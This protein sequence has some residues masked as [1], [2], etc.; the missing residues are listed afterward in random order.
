MLNNPVY[1]NGAIYLSG[2]MQ[3][4]KDLGAEWRIECSKILKSM[5]YN[6]VDIS[7]MDKEYTDK[8]G[9]LYFILD[10]KNHLQYKSNF[11]KHF[12][13]AD[14]EL[15]KNDCDALIVLYDESVR[16]GAGT[17][18]E[19]HEAYQLGLPVFLVSAYEDWH[20]EVPGWM[21]GETTK[22]FTSFQQLYEYLGY[23]S[24]KHPGILKKDIYG[25]HG[26]NNHYLCSLCG[27]VFEKSK[28]HFVSKVTPTYCSS[29]VDLITKTNEGHID[30]YEFI[31]EVLQNDINND[32]KIARELREA[33]NHKRST[34]NAIL[35]QR[36]EW[37]DK[38]QN[39]Y[40]EHTY[41]YFRGNNL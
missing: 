26:V 32:I 5:G 24:E 7:R 2:G 12:I 10:K 38:S 36:P 4:A 15:I 6:P 23:L 31:T 19:I 20:S 34:D 29:C 28:H 33:E 39:D 11:R 9:Q 25:N 16:R 30:R 17:T 22:I 8:H 14:I 35:D 3:H 21:Q 40:D 18:S 1:P 37:A 13:H 27:C 41:D